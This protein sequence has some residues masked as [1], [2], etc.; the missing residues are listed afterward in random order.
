MRIT[1]MFAILVLFQILLAGTASGERP[2]IAGLQAQIE[3][4]QMQSRPLIGEIKV[5]SGNCEPDGWKYCNG[6]LIRI[7]KYPELFSVIG[8]TYGGDGRTTFA[9]PDLRGRVPIG[10]GTGVALTNRK[11]GQ[12]GGAESVTLTESQL[13]AHD[14]TLRATNSN[15]TQT[16]PASNILAR[17]STPQYLNATTSVLMGT[18]SIGSTGSN[19]PHANVQPFTV[20]QFIIAVDNRVARF[21]YTASTWHVEEANSPGIVI[22]TDYEFTSAAVDYIGID[23]LLHVPGSGN[24]WLAVPKNHNLAMGPITPMIV[25]EPL[26]DDMT[27]IRPEP[28]W[29]VRRANVTHVAVTTDHEFTSGGVNYIGLEYLALD[30][31]IGSIWVALSKNHN[32]ETGPETPRI[33]LDPNNKFVDQRGIPG[34]HWRVDRHDRVFGGLKY[35]SAAVDYIA[36]EYLVHFDGIG[37][38]WVAM[39]RNYDLTLGPVIPVINL[40]PDVVKPNY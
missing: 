19:A 10:E 14:H 39:P 34:P 20:L 26:G 21:P 40:A 25:L 1:K 2:S 29:P 24:V 22:T 31:G 32:L 5:F 6:L 18:D 15:A 13:P 16:A 33:V 38:V 8:N 27:E 23:Y 11:L 35:T 30:E 36:L 9:L 3:A 28:R 37:T 7:S 12:E 4:L 17:A